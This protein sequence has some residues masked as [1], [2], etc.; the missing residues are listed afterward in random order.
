MPTPG[1]HIRLWAD[2]SEVDG[3]ESDKDV[4]DRVE[5]ILQKIKELG[6]HF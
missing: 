1:T 4:I 2:E 5:A 3:N 6:C